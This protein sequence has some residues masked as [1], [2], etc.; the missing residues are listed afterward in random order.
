MATATASGGD[1][2]TATAATAMVG[3]A[4][5]P[6]AHVLRA[7]QAISSARGQAAATAKAAAAAHQ[8][9]AA[10]GDVAASSDDGG[11]G[12]GNAGAGAGAG[13]ALSRRRR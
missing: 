3:R 5:T 8:A 6:T 12:A 13:G 1:F 9:Q 11:A 7:E 4:A 10:P 2:T